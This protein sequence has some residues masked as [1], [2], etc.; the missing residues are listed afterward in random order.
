MLLSINSLRCHQNYKVGSGEV[1]SIEEIIPLLRSVPC[2]EP[3]SG[4][5]IG[6]KRDAQQERG[7]P[8]GTIHHLSPPDLEDLNSVSQH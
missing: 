6:Q 8:K 2:S 4:V 7:Y 3:T 1:N 5:C